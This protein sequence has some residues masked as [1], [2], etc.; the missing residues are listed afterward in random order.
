M[1]KIEYPNTIPMSKNPITDAE[2]RKLGIDKKSFN[3]VENLDVL[4]GQ[5][6]NMVL[7]L[8]CKNRNIMQEKF[9]KQ[10]L[11]KG[12][13]YLMSLG[14]Y[15][16]LKQER[17]GVKL[18]KPASKFSSI[19]RPYNGQDLTNKKLLVIRTGGIGDLLF[20]QPNLIHLKEKY[21]SCE[22]SLACGP[23]YHSMVENWDC[24]DNV[25]LLPVNRGIVARAD[26]HAIFEG[27]IERCEMA[28]T[29]NAYRLFTDWLGI[30]LPDEKLIPHQKPKDVEVEYAKK[31]LE[32][33][34]VE[35]GEFYLFQIRASSPIRTPRPTIWKTL[36]DKL[37]DDGKKIIITDSPYM[38]VQIDSFC[39]A[40]G[41][42]KNKN[43]FNFCH[44]SK[45]LDK[46]IALASMAKMTISPDSSFIHIAQSLGVKSFGVYGAFDGDIRLSTYK[47]CDYYLCKTKEE[48]G[49]CFLHGQN[50]CKNSKN[51]HPICY[52]NIDYDIC[53]K[54]IKELA[55]D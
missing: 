21:P 23:Q 34:G 49:P 17:S 2:L 50:P 36:I 39:D 44:Y 35:P 12:Q 27:V 8:A 37:L 13:T 7:A 5:V 19:Y 29:T 30:N 9:K 52:D 10:K 16:Q 1:D 55:D 14:I 53:Y 22:I 47:D 45:S 24:V 31:I 25:H 4:R 3:I 41:D 48:C 33:W 15:Q 18:F 32:D 38:D 11:V 26:Y 20:I 46:S 40:F 6:P 54:Q 43:I 42:H 51:G 28:E